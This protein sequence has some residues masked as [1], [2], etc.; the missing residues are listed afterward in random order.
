MSHQSPMS[1]ELLAAAYRL[2][3]LNDRE[4][5]RRILNRLLASDPDNLEAWGLLLRLTDNYREEM[6]YLRQILA[7]APGLTWAQQ[8]L[9]QL[10]AYDLEPDANLSS[11]VNEQ[12]WQ[13]V[14]A[15]PESSSRRFP[16]WIPVLFL[17]GICLA[18]AAG[19]FFRRSGG[20]NQES[21]VSCEKLISS[22]L[23]LSD[24]SCNQIGSNQ[25]C[26]GNVHLDA[27][28]NPSVPSDFE[29]VGD[30]I[31]VQ[32]LLS[33]SASPLNL[34]S[35]EWGIAL[36]K[37]EANIA[38]TTPGELATFIVFGNTDLT[39]ESGDMQAF[40]FSSGFGQIICEAVPFDGIYVIMPDGS[41]INFTANGT[42]IKLFGEGLLEAQRDQKL[43][44]SVVRGSGEVT[45]NG[46]SQPVGEGWSV[47]V[48]L[49]GL[50][51]SGSPS[52]PEWIVRDVLAQSCTMFNIGCDNLSPVYPDGAQGTV[53][54]GSTAAAQL[55]EVTPVPTVKPGEPTYTPTLIPTVRPG[56]PTYTPTSTPVPTVKPGDPTYTP[57]SPPVPT[58]KPGDPTYTPVPLPT[59][60][61][62]PVPTATPIPPTNTP[63]PPTATPIPPTATPVPPTDTPVPAGTCDWSTAGNG[64]FNITNNTGGTVNMT[65]VT[66]NAWPGSSG[67]LTKVKFGSTIWNS[68]ASSPPVGFVPSGGPD[69]TVGQTKSLDLTFDSA[70]GGS[71]YSIQV[72]FD[73][74]SVSIS[75]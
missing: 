73:G 18:A 30:V 72:T 43:R 6:V 66:I 46:Q 59:N 68:S 26:Y 65:Y 29:T 9:D 53:V 19:I 35:R 5:A 36:F 54:A 20:S 10:A 15:V 51:P 1:Q 48:P 21:A 71:G 12:G 8:R 49:N 64:S 28:L 25:V 44:L 14:D 61:L 63:V 40:Y 42:D 34:D 62:P 11:P 23:E 74:C 22:A 31:G 70:A 47:G 7:R 38:Y 60:T 58:V 56:D 24:S 17:F 55:A 52:A 27:E 13:T 67:A 3:E 69:L 41:G 39:N 32:N 37:L 33:L 45:A 75:N 2:I 4:Q 50:D 16:L 57:T